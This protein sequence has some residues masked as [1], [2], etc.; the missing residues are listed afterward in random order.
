[1]KE[2]AEMGRTYYIFKSGRLR[3]KQNT[4]YLEVEGEERARPIPVE[5]VEQ[6]YLFGEVDMNTKLLNFLGQKGIVV[7]CFNYYGFYTGSFYPRET[8][9]S[10]HLIVRQVEH[11][12]DHGKRLEIAREFVLG[13][14]HNLHRNL[15]YY[16]NRG[17]DVDKVVEAVERE[18]GSILQAAT[19]EQLRGAE[20]RCRDHYY[21]AFNHILSLSEPFTRRVKRPPDNMINALLSFGNTM[22]YT[23]VLREIYVTQLNPTISYLHEPS[24]RRFSL[25]LDIAEVF[26]PIIVDRV[27]FSLLNKRTLGEADFLEEVGFTYLNE[28]GRKKFVREFEERLQATV[29]HRR[30]KRSVS[31]RQLLR[32]ECYRLIRHLVGME[33]YESLKAWW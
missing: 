20:G 33:R 19:V 17:R 13:A 23:A 22:L 32:L 15:L 6:I 28:E 12:L 2:V 26:K 3:R 4:L 11:Y 10:G 7:H 31:Y 30:L 25:A 8:N 16:R 27:I 29:K 1:M 14:W 21:R 5:D 24:A 18:K 9:I